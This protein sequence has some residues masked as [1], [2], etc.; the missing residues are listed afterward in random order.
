MK[1]VRVAING[2]GRIG[3]AF[4]KLAIA[5]PELQIVA[6]ND[7][8]NP[9]N[10]A[11]LLRYDSGYGRS[12]LEI[13]IV[14]GALTV[15]GQSIKFLQ[16]ANPAQLPWSSLGVDV[17]VE[18]TGLFTSYER[19][20]VHLTAGAHK[21]VVTAPLKGEP[22]PGVVGATV[23]MGINEEKLGSCQISSNASCTTNS[24]SPIIQIMLE[25]IGVEKAILNTVHAYTASQ[26]L[27]DSPD[28][29]DFRRGR[30][31]AH[32][33][34]PS[35]TGAAI[36]VTKAIP[37]LEN[38][39]DGIAMRVPVLLG[40]IAD[41]TFIASRVTTVDEVNAV[42]RQAAKEPRWQGI[43]SVTEE[44]L[45]SSDVVGSLYAAIADLAFTKVVGGNL[46]KIVSWYDNEIG[47]TNT[48]VAHVIKTGQV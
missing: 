43:F 15:N 25:K 9:D 20:R 2:L 8:G 13:K 14:D 1:T 4:L 48:L 34:I 18:S 30:A 10:L 45:V 42:L 17:V 16:E 37:E 5:R 21:V 24:V 41:L 23:L 27:V 33:I 47:Y 3:R 19:A 38:K 11:Y 7:L 40:S 28:A 32:N 6:V 44:P 46:V 36:A 39:F 35:T 26:R 12:D 31:G 22:T 29:K